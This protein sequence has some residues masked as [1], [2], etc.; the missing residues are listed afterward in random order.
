MAKRNSVN[1]DMLKNLKGFVR[2]GASSNV[3]DYIPTGHFNLDYIIN[4]G[5]SPDN[6]DLSDDPDYDPSDKLGLPLGR[7]VELFGEE[8]GGKSSLAYRIVGNAQKKGYT[9]AWIDTEQSFSD[10]LSEINGAD[11]DEL[12]FSDMSNTENPDQVYYAEDVF[13]GIIDLIK[14]GVKVIVL[15]SVANL[16]PKARMEA[17]SEQQLPGI[18]SRLMSESLKKV[19]NYAGVHGALVICINQLR[20]KIGVMFGNPIGTPGGRSL[21]HNASI[22][23]QITIQKSK[24]DQIIRVGENGR[25]ILIGRKAHARL[26]KNRMAKPYLENIVIPMYFE[27][28]FPDIDDIIVST[29]KQV[30]T[31]SVRKNVYT[32]K[33]EDNEHKIEG[34]EAFIKYIKEKQLTLALAKAA[35][36][37]AKESKTLLPPELSQWLKDNPETVETKV[38]ETPVVE[39]QGEL[40]ET[41]EVKKSPGRPRKNKIGQVG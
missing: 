36:E 35:Q 13:D 1:I 9:C 3:E 8:G 22:R 10:N 29:A 33:Q 5:E 40:D 19:V 34:K 21:K 41:K 23:L 17:V 7:V 31:I 32:W 37:S 11:K 24:E 26:V 20:E 38:E 14:A 4:H 15:D 2:K 27:A 12:L 28:Y 16:I 18:L 6:I 30:K 25:E 39:E